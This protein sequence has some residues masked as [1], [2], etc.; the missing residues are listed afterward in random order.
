MP[1]I[2][3]SVGFSYNLT[4]NIMAANNATKEKK[5]YMRI[6]NLCGLLG[7]ILPWL[8][9]ISAYL[10]DHSSNPVYQEQWWWSISATYYQSPALVAV[11]TPAAL[12]LIS[13]IG[14]NTTDNIVTSASG[15]FGL[16][17]ILFPCK[18]GWF[19]AGAH[20]GFFQLPME[21]SNT[22]HCACAAFFFLLIAL[23]SLLLFTKTK[24][25][26]TM[27]DRKKRRNLVYRICGIGMLVFEGVFALLA[28]F[29]AP[30]WT[31]MV[32]EIILLHLFGFSWL[33]KGD[34]FPFLRDLPEDEE[35]V[36]EDVIL[37]AD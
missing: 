23:N 1:S 31:T 17:I 7:V 16:G 21:I 9:L 37:V 34:A 12:V 11:L 32:T 18:V 10:V 8:A 5:M 28:V 19:K 15:I 27:T 35:P 2:K 36:K 4:L 29:D 20:V 14:Y 26:E 22:I 13:Y 33:T 30:G 25:N 6:R 3:P 24:N